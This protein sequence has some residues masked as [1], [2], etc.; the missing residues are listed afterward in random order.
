MFTTTWKALLAHYDFKKCLKNLPRPLM[1]LFGFLT[2]VATHCR[3][4]ITT[5][6]FMGRGN[7]YI[8]LF[9][10]LYCELPTKGKQLPAFSLLRSDQD[11]N[12]DLRGGRELPHYHRVPIQDLSCAKLKCT[13]KRV[14]REGGGRYN[15]YTFK[16]VLPT[17]EFHL[18]GCS[19]TEIQIRVFM[20][21]RNGVTVELI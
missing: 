17:N 10:A 7:Q 6:S 16:H 9:K 8:Q 13:C 19:W 1:C 3:G 11:L 15:G 20:A 2:S 12:S 4:H 21:T 5:G 18:S 14:T